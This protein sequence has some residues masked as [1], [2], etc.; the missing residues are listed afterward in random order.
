MSKSLDTTTHHAGANACA[1]PHDNPEQAVSGPGA[2]PASDRLI[3]IVPVSLLRPYKGNA[4]KHSKKQI[5]QIARSITRFGFTNPVLIDDNNQIIAGHGRVEA[6]T[7]LALSAVPARRLSHLSEAEIRAYVLAD[8]RLAEK[9]GWDRELLAYELQGLIDLEFDVELTGFEGPEID[10]I[11]DDA[12]GAEGEAPRPEDDIPE[13]RLGPNITRLGDLWFLGNHRLLCGYAL[14]QSAYERLLGGEK[15]Q[16]IFTDPPNNVP[17][18]RHVCGKAAIRHREFSMASS[19]MSQEGFTAFL[20]TAFQ[21]LSAHSVDGSIHNVCM[22]WRHMAEMMTAGNA[23][24]SELKNVCIWVKTNGGTGAFY[25]SRHEMIFIWKSG[26]AAHINN[27]ERGQHG[28]SRTNIWEYAGISS[29]R[30]GRL[31]ELAMHPTV[32]P[33]ALVAD[34]IKDCSKRNSIVLDP[35]VGSGTTVIAAERTGRRARAI[36]I[37]PAYVDVAVKRWQTFTGKSAT[38]AATGQT[39]KEVEESRASSSQ[40]RPGHDGAAAVGEA[41]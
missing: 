19:E 34:A 20:T 9:A 22:D 4:R 3:E 41:R 33:V 38:L 27:F 15:A 29:A 18:D 10:L 24:Y 1:D 6:A 26:V 37:D 40:G 12:K 28:R 11:L 13:P 31:E 7:E 17:I 5:R 36:E 16:F 8:N 35:F 2:F 21:H 39:Y 30:A 23:V 32:K 14:E 25:R